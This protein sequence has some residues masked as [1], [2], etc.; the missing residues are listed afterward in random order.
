MVLKPLGSTTSRLNPVQPW[1]AYPPIDT[2]LFGIRLNTA[3]EQPKNAE[4]PMAVILLCSV[5]DVIDEALYK[6]Y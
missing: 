6:L 3:D 4:A 5:M 1:N 2:R